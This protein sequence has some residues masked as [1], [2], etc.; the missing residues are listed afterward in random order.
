M[1]SVS[2]WTK[3]SLIFS[4][5]LPVSCGIVRREY[6]Q[7]SGTCRTF[8]IQPWLQYLGPSCYLHLPI[9]FMQTINRLLYGP[10]PEDRVRAWQT[11]LRQESRVLDRVMRQVRPLAA[12]VG[13]LVLT[14]TFS[15]TL[16]RI[17]CDK[18]LSNL[19]KRETT[20]RR[21]FWRARS[22]EVIR[23]RIDSQ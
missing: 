17:R 6:S 22:C 10:T 3:S 5:G 1:P 14:R 2:R 21:G 7:V 23:R 15:W 19:Q 13:T 16:K 12:S 11:K 20:S 4:G 18:P 8:L 9:S